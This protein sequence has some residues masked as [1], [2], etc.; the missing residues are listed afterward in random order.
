MTSVQLLRGYNQKHIRILDEKLIYIQHSYDR[1]VYT[2][3]N[4]FPFENLFGYLP[5]LPLHVVYGQQGGAREDTVG[6]A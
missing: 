6:E 5:T 3:T 2:S 1:V 4:K